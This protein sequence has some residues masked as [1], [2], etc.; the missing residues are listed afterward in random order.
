M[1]N[2]NNNNNTDNQNEIIVDVRCFLMKNR[3]YL[4]GYHLYVHYVMIAAICLLIVPTFAFNLGFVRVLCNRR[5]LRIPANIYILNTNIIDLITGGILLPST[6]AHH[7]FVAITYRQN[8]P[9][10]TLV[11]FLSHMCTW[12][13]FLMVFAVIV[14]RY[15]TVTRP[16]SGQSSIRM[17]V[18]NCIFIWMAS[19]AIVIS[20]FFFEDYLISNLLSSIMG[21]LIVFISIALHVR[22]GIITKRIQRAIRCHSTVGTNHVSHQDNDGDDEKVKKINNK[23]MSLRKE[24]K[25]I[26]LTLMMLISL[27]VCYLPYTIFMGTWMIMG[28]WHYTFMHAA[29]VILVT[30][31]FLNPLLYWYHMPTLRKNVIAFFMCRRIS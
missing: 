23:P 26:M 4:H 19:L 13:S 11:V 28:L 21:P 31:T 15:L 14:E 12:V 6:C 18:L 10:Y 3:Y 30:K 7:L 29:S 22:L 5:I 8:C 17:H 16:F 27:V 1:Y 24:K 2:N 20:S 25:T 9:L